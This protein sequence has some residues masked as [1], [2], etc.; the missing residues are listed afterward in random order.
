MMKHKQEMV[1]INGAI[2]MIDS[3]CVDL[4]ILFNK[5]GLATKYSCQG[6]TLN[7]YE[8]MFSEE[9]DDDKIEEF[10]MKFDNKYSH[11]PFVGKFFK[12]KRKVSGEIANNWVYH[13]H[14]ILGS[15]R[16]FE[17]IKSKFNIK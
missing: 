10:I 7:S 3:E 2:Y 5:I 1:E 15:K 16:D 17:I 6:H 11:S 9:V 8:I 12:W 14:S 13:C 4:V